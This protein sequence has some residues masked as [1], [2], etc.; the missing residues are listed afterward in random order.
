MEMMTAIGKIK[1]LRECGVHLRFERGHHVVCSLNYALYE[2]L[3][4]AIRDD[5]QKQELEALLEVNALHYRQLADSDLQ[6]E[7]LLMGDY[8]IDDAIFLDAY[9]RVESFSKETLSA[10]RWPDK[11]VEMHVPREGYK[12]VAE[13][14]LATIHESESHNPWE[15]AR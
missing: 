6:P 1:F 7:D 2:E 13:K 5:E 3:R 12:L 9:R 11:W 15:V 14:C 10:G 8:S 4:S